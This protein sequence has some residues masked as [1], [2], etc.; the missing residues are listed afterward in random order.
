MQATMRLKKKDSSAAAPRKMWLLR[1]LLVSSTATGFLSPAPR[2]L[3]SSPCRLEERRR[4]RYAGNTVQRAA[5]AP[6]VPIP[7]SLLE[8]NDGKEIEEGPKTY[9]KAPKKK[10]SLRRVARSIG[11]YAWVT[12]SWQSRFL[13]V[14]AISA[15]VLGKMISVSV[16]FLLQQCVDAAAANN[17][18]AA[19]TKACL[20][21][22]FARFA[23]TL[24]SEARS[25]CYA[26]A[27]QQAT[28]AYAG[29]LHTKMLALDSKFHAENPTGLLSVAFSRGAK[30][31][32]TLLFQL[33]FTV[34]PTIVELGLSASLLASKFG[35]TVGLATVVTFTAYAAFTAVIVDRKVRVKRRL[36]ELDNAKAAYLVD[37]LA[38]YETVQLFENHKAE[39]FR[40]DQFLRR[41]LKAFVASSRINAIL[42]LGQAL[43]FSLGL[44]FCLCVTSN[45]P[46]GGSVV[47]VNGLLIQLAA[48]MAYLGYTV[49]EIRQ[50]VVDMTVTEDIL[51]KP[52][53]ETPKRDGNRADSSPRL[54]PSSPPA[55][56]FDHV[57][58]NFSSAVAL[59]DVSFVA[60]A[61][62]VTVLAGAS[63]SGKSSA[64]R[65]VAKLDQPDAGTV[66]LNYDDHSP[67]ST[68][69][70]QDIDQTNLRDIVGFVPQSP[71]LFDETTRWNVRY[72]DL[73][74][75][76]D[77]KLKEVI[78]TTK[79]DSIDLDKRIGE[80]AVKLS[81]GERQ[82]VA[83]ARALLRDPLLVCAD[84]PTSAA[85]AQTERA[86]LDALVADEHERTVLVVAHRLNALAPLAD[87]IVVFDQG[88]VVQAGSHD[89]LLQNPHSKYAQL[90][91]AATSLKRL[92]KRED[93]DA[94][95]SEQQQEELVQQ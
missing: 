50:A 32:Q 11:K 52:L 61:G 37:S 81:G 6:E 25:L 10:L 67:A 38:N 83:I 66:S 77:E 75:S 57:R 84:E 45:A 88:K 80:R 93:D 29:A 1:L 49:S 14:C 22:C 12:A 92:K 89:E 79:L 69:D 53:R 63:G 13:I 4:S 70:I 91:R 15:L 30:G 9:S 76:D 73:K 41:M 72:G 7:I 5:A 43:I 55:V 34:L 36:V 17:A 16:P 31:F 33:L 74:N 40:F 56:V 8:L 71:Q 94:S 62:K 24:A 68:I 3:S 54:L 90:W 18:Q 39:S 48:P 58:R 35:A 2:V 46:S 47:A 27:S 86:L 85:D 21:Y 19:A 78:K 51:A 65:L 20:A 26:H 23:A 60:P 44:A 59:D 42:N 87:H 64:L 95:S 82:R 28:R